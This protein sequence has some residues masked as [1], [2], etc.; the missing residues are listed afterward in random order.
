MG[1]FKCLRIQSFEN[2]KIKGFY[3]HKVKP[4]TL[5]VNVNFSIKPKIDIPKNHEKVKDHIIQ[6]IGLYK[7]ENQFKN[8]ELPEQWKYDGIRFTYEH[9]IYHLVISP[10]LSLG[11]DI[12]L[13]GPEK[14]ECSDLK[15]KYKEICQCI[16]KLDAFKSDEIIEIQASRKDSV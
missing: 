16:S 8:F 9:S 6:K 10:I 4:L 1:D 12:Y 11:L 2:V 3:E 14:I 7:I 5:I 13:I 15:N